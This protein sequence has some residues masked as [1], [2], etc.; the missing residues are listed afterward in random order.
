VDALPDIGPLR[1]KVER[2]TALRQAA[3][4]RKAAVEKDIKTLGDEAELLVL[5]SS[6]FRTLIDAEVTT[7]VQVVERLMTEGLQAV[8]PDQDL[9]VRAVVETKRGK[10]SVELLT[11]QTQGDTVIE[12]LSSD[13]FGGAVSTVESVLLR[14]L[15]MQRRGIRPLLL[16]DESLPAFDANYVINMGNFLSLLCERLG[17]DVLLVTHNPALVEAADRAYRVVKRSGATQYE[18]LR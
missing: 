3:R 4:A 7:S 15:V 16:L 6:L 8:F 1:A 2:A 10:I 9:A 11:V 12:G 17:L 18:R 5:V 13:A 14:I